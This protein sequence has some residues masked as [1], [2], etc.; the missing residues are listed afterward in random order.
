MEKKKKPWYVVL[1]N[2][3][4][5]IIC[6]IVLVVGG[7][8]LFFKIKYDVNVFSAISQIRMLNETVNEDEL[9]PNKY[10]EVDIASA[11]VM[12]NSQIENLIVKNDNGYTI[13]TTGITDTMDV[14][15]YLTDKEIGAIVNVLLI[16]NNQNAVNIGGKT[17]PF[18]LIQVKFDNIVENS[19]DVNI[20]LKVNVEEIKNEM[21]SFPLS[22]VK[23]YIPN[24]L[25]FSSTVTV[26]KGTNAY[27]YTTTSKSLTINNL[28]VEQTT[29]LLKTINTF[30]SFG[31]ENTINELI[32]NTFV[33]A[34]IGTEENQGFAY[35]LKS[36]GA[37]DFTF[38][39]QN[40][41]NYFVI[42]K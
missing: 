41:K 8:F 39:T 22:W 3:L 26:T 34:L 17:L 20:A 10:T 27:E 11:Q 28:N 40:D 25:Y 31:N 7:I 36:L 16:Q 42:V 1:F 4:L 24:D 12:V 14:S 32:G 19:A 13:D 9:F 30:V 35:S 23:K 18:E 29:S 33:D 5:T 6:I 15:I 21:N 2:I 37:S 38:T